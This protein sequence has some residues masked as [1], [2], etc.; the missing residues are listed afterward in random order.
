MVEE[1][2]PE[3]PFVDDLLEVARNDLDASRALIQRLVAIADALLAS[4]TTVAGVFAGLAFS[5]DRKALA[6]VA[7]PL[8]LLL[9]YLDGANWVHF[10][11]VSSRV[12]LLERLFGAYVVALRETATVRVQAIADLRTEVDQ[13]QFGTERTFAPPT[14]KQ[15]WRNNRSRARWWPYTLI[16]V[17]LM[18]CGVFI[19]HDPQSTKVCVSTPNGGILQ[20]DSIPL[21]VSGPITL[22]PCPEST[23]GRFAPIT[24]TSTRLAP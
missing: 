16:A 8:V 6:L 1:S 5:N 19:I 22:V 12:R 15:I 20:L 14:P 11:R 3:L 4:A 2:I 13:Y 23:A 18:V 7:V 24:T 10:R 17:I 21:A 9:G